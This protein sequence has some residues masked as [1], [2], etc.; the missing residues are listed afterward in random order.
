MKGTKTNSSRKLPSPL[1]RSVMVLTLVA[2]RGGSQAITSATAPQNTSLRNGLWFNGR[3]FERRTMYSVQGRF[4]L[5][6][7]ARVDRDLDLAG[8][9]IV[10][11]FGEAH[12]HNIGTGVE[13]WDRKA[14]ARYQADGVFYVKIQGNLPLTDRGKRTLGI[15]TPTGIDAV[16]AQ[17]SITASGG[18]PIALTEGLLER[19]YFPGFTREA[20]RDHRYF[21]V[22][23][24][25]EFQRKWPEILALSPDF[26]KVFLWF[27]DEFEKRNK[28]SAYFGQKGLDPRFLRAIVAK[29]HSNGLRVSVHIAN[30]ADFHN[31]VAAGVDEIAHFPLLGPASIDMETATAAAR[32][33]IV[34]DTTCGLARTLPASILP[35]TAL[36]ATV[37]LQKRNLRLLR[38]RGVR[39]AIGS[40]NPTDSSAGEVAYLKGLGVL[41]NASLLRMWTETTP[42]SIF[43]GR[44]IGELREG[45][46]ASFLLLEGDP[47]KDWR[48]LRKIKLRFKQGFLLG[49]E[50][51]PGRE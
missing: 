23:S 43:P 37:E 22:D 24:E 28:D 49:K 19:G 40:D 16:L 5:R 11:P 51:G 8:A 35:P 25:V 3:S 27:S 33:G 39:I 21:T 18:H 50:G 12:N 1:L 4:T 7:P 31:A 47:L 30:A 44:A 36:P 10:P 46:E 29:A 26:I 6:K 42:Q 45:F 2:G 20:L 38:A 15:G 9:W 13:Q 41:E 34:V 32:Q 14:I 48:N 17:G